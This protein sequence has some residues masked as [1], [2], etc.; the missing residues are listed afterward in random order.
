VTASQSAQARFAR[1]ARAKG[2]TKVGR[3]AKSTRQPQ[4]QAQIARPV[5]RNGCQFVWAAG[6]LGNAQQDR[7]PG[8][9]S[10]FSDALAVHGDAAKRLVAEFAPLPTNLG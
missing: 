4:A 9:V 6:E 1:Q 5:P 8:V 2:K 10:D 7:C 3:A